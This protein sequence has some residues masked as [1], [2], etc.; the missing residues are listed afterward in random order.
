MSNHLGL[1]ATLATLQQLLASGF[2]A[3][4]LDDLLAGTLSV[5][6]IAPERIPANATNP[7][8]NLFLYNQTRN[9]GWHNN[10]LPSRDRQGERLTN[11]PL[12]LDLHLLLAAYGIA[13]FQAEVML[14]AAMQLLHDQPVLGRE[15]IRELLTP[16]P[17]KPN[18]PAAFQL[19]GL[20]DQLEQLRITAV[21]LSS[22][23]ISRI[24]SMLQTPARPSAAYQLSVVLM[25][26]NRP[27]R[28][29]L[30]VTSRNLYAQPLRAPRIDRIEAELGAG[31]PITSSSRV[32]ISGQNLRSNSLQL[33]VSGIDLSSTI[34]ELS[35]SSLLFALRLPPPPPAGTVPEAL[36]AGGCTLQLVH[37]QLMGEP[38]RPHGGQ[39][40][41]LAAFV[42]TPQASFS[43]LPGVVTT[44]VDGVTYRSGV[45]RISASPRLGRRQQLRLL[46]NEH[47]PPSD[48][49]PRAYSFAAAEGNGISL[50]ADSSATVD[51]SFGPLV[52]GRYL[53]RLEVDGAASGLSLDADGRFAA[54]ELLL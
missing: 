11:P 17:A 18:L 28:T 3:L 8:L 13:D 7:Q 53:L 33:L 43:L 14:G 50:P 19:A 40:S 22:D 48:R 52:A 29:A 1:A 4:K 2:A 39:S 30:P 25:N 38:P 49:P 23:E 32:R 15:Q 20:A 54:P 10:Q 36:R 5:S 47:L 6:C 51:I 27:T 16:G 46:L 9:S 31:E 34:S 26:T 44:L 12:A 24:W 37:L 41:N 21:N 42:L 45:I 35:D